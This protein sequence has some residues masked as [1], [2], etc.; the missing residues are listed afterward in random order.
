MT[1][2]VPGSYNPTESAFTTELPAEAKMLMGGV[3]MTQTFPQ[4]L[5]GQE[6]MNQGPYYDAEI[7]RAVKLEEVEHDPY[8]DLFDNTAPPMKWDPMTQ[9]A[10]PVDDSWESFIDD[11]AW[12]NE[13]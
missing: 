4:N 12:R 13:K 2:S 7:P 1:H 10:N 9:A 11:N 3:D 5:Y 6:W 8:P